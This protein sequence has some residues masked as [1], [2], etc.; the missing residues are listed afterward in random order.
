[1]PHVQFTKTIM[2]YLL[3]PKR[4]RYL[5]DIQVCQVHNL[6]NLE[7][8]TYNLPMPPAQFDLKAMIPCL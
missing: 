3:K 5:T 1:M 2:P 7:C 6:P 8:H 4:P